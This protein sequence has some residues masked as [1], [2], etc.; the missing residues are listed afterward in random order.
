MSFDI[1]INRDIKNINIVW[2]AYI[3]K[4]LGRF[5][6]NDSAPSVATKMDKFNTDYCPKMYWN[7]GR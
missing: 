2:E 5:R 4:V 3:E 6:M 1:E 7:N